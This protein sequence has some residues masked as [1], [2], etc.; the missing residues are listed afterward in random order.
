MEKEPATIED[1]LSIA[2]RLEA[3]RAALR[4]LEAPQA[5]I[6]K[7]EVTT[8][9]RNVNVIRSSP[10]T[11]GQ[12]LPIDLR[13]FRLEF[14]NRKHKES[15]K[16]QP[17]SQSSTRKKA[18]SPQAQAPTESSRQGVTAGQAKGRGKGSGRGRI[19]CSNCNKSGHRDKD[20]ARPKRLSPP[21]EEE[22]EEEVEIKSIHSSTAQGLTTA[23][24]YY[25][26]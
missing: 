22:E 8:K 5:N 9:A 25:S 2:I 3:Y 14:D 1:A 11:Q 13:A 24:Y 18:S 20:C 16:D 21:L 4:L 12:Q 17:T 15:S 6:S 26:T 7:G 10:S 23:R 19:Q